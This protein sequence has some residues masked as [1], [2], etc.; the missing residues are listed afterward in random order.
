MAETLLDYLII[1]A[2][3]AGL[4]LAAL[5]ERDGRRDY[6]VLEAADAPGAFFTRFPRHRVLI[7][8]N[9]PHTGSTDAEL[10]LRLDWNSLL[11]DEKAPLFTSYT[12]R[13]FP[14]ADLFVRYLADFAAATGARVRY[15][16]RVGA[17]RPDR[18]APGGH[19]RRGRHVPGPVRGGGYRGVPA[20]PAGDPG[21][22]DW[23]SAT[24]RC[25]STRG[26]T[27]TSGCSSS[28]RAT[29]PSRPPTT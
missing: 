5:L 19:R 27:S 20:V 6:L 29:P 28:A 11:A 24:T 14:P 21:H 13:Y 9:K 12:E 22:R 17:G 26:T 23:R 7:S 1:G 4:Q 15:G 8:V 16:A 10:N 18:R 25:R 3:P 2:G